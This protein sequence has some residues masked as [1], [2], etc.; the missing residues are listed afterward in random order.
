MP[1][2]RGR[3]DSFVPYWTFKFERKSLDSKDVVT[4]QGLR[5]FKVQGSDPGFKGIGY[6]TKGAR[7]RGYEG[8]RVRGCEGARVR[9]CE[10][11]RVPGC[12]GARV[13][14]CEV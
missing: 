1:N 13:R 2:C 11:A 3:A 14:G 10:D 9:G 5:S 12:Q 4:F 7:V 8:A 6:R